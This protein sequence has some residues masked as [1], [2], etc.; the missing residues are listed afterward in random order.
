MSVKLK[1]TDGAQEARADLR[2]E[3]ELQLLAHRE[4][5]VATLKRLGRGAGLWAERG[6]EWDEP[7]WDASPETWPPV[8][9]ILWLLGQWY[10]HWQ[11]ATF[12][13]HLREHPGWCLDCH[14]GAPRPDGWNVWTCPEHSDPRAVKRLAENFG[15]SIGH[16]GER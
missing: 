3:G 4:A 15:F 13:I 16:G 10:D 12:L 9:K 1:R 14:E 11:H 7:D 6:W 2:A 8:A 5:M